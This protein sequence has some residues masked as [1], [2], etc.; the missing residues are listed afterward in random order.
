MIDILHA[1]MGVLKYL[2]TTQVTLSAFW[3]GGTRTGAS[4]RKFQAFPVGAGFGGGGDAAAGLG[5]EDIL[6]RYKNRA[7]EMTETMPEENN[8][9]TRAMEILSGRLAKTSRSR[10]NM[11]KVQRKR[12]MRTGGC[13]WFY[14]RSS[15]GQEYGP[16]CEEQI[17]RW[18]DR[19]I[20]DGTTLVR[21]ENETEYL[22]LGFAMGPTAQG[23]EGNKKRLKEDRGT[24]DGDAGGCRPV[25]LEVLEEEVK[26]DQKQAA[27]QE[28]YSIN[29]HKIQLTGIDGKPTDVWLP[30]TIEARHTDGTLDVSLLSG[31]FLRS[32]SMAKVFPK[33][34][35]DVLRH[36]KVLVIM[37]AFA[38]ISKYPTV[39]PSAS[40]EQDEDEE[41]MY[42][43]G[44][45]PDLGYPG[46]D[47]DDGTKMGFPGHSSDQDSEERDPTLRSGAT[48][49]VRTYDNPF[50][51]GKEMWYP[52]IVRE[53]KEDGCILTRDLDPILFPNNKPTFYPM[54][55][56]RFPE[57]SQLLGFDSQC[58]SGH[59]CEYFNGRYPREYD[60]YPDC[61]I[62][63]K[64]M[65]EIS[66]FYHCDK[67]SWDCCSACWSLRTGGGVDAAGDEHD[68]RVILYKKVNNPETGKLG[69]EVEAEMRNLKEDFHERM[70]ASGI[71]PQQFRDIIQDL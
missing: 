46:L 66:E 8:S 30:C 31:D 22:R 13:L 51:P 7:I 20:V 47:E 23:K 14:K 62:C 50:V 61:D 60:E 40:E 28:E 25:R 4:R 37:Q 18:R 34:P 3:R 53:V 71:N 64:S 27:V 42:I 56:I 19:G 2:A 63:S 38:P 26:M 17:L 39:M 43:G 24:S 45:D 21:R 5:F 35:V 16:W 52:A 10:T 49:E 69:R 70:Q 68:R 32:I 15:V 57:K 11:F 36:I 59:D 48:V 29:Q 6:K 44:R 41:P 67:C 55:N 33:S 9:K 54:R 58:P 65:Q 1:C 12:A